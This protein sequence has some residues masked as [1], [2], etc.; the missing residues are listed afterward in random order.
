VK[1]KPALRIVTAL[2]GIPA[3]IGLVGWGGGQIFTL[4]MFVVTLACL[5]EYYRIAFPAR[6]SERA[7]GI[8]AGALTG[9]GV[10]SGWPSAGLAGVTVLLFCGHLFFAGPLEERFNRLAWTVL[11]TL[12]IGFLLPHAALLY[13]LVD[14]PRWIFF[15]LLVVM[16]GDSAA[17]FVG[18]TLGKKKLYPEISPGKTVEGAI[19]ST[20][21]SLVAGAAAGNFLL[22]A[23]PW[24]EMLGLALVSSVLGQVGDLFESWI[25]RVFGVKDSSGL[26]PGHGGLLDRM[27]SLIFP[28]VLTAYYV[29][30]FHL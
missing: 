13:G 8:L 22:P 25:K 18:S 26:I 19:A 30:I 14:G 29:R 2:I 20:A 15:I 16:S 17:Y 5:W 6:P 3:V 21:A 1:S 9:F 11:G 10:L 4:L 24:P 28:L 27:D 23:H 12:Y 7:V